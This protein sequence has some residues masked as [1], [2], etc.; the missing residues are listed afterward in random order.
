M[1]W[2]SKLVTVDSQ[3]YQVDSILAKAQD[4]RSAFLDHRTVLDGTTG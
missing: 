1:G 4:N 2:E 3:P